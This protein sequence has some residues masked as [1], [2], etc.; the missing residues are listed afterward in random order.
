MPYLQVEALAFPCLCCIIRLSSGFSWAID[1]RC[2]NRY[3]ALFLD[4]N[5]RC[6]AVCVCVDQVNEFFMFEHHP[7]SKLLGEFFVF[8]LES[9]DL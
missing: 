6:F 2:T 4:R 9:G 5:S 8:V 3:W 1:T 7:F